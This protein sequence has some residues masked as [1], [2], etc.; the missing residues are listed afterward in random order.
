MQGCVKSEYN[1]YFVHV[2]DGIIFHKN[3]SIYIF[4]HLK[5]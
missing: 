1:L 2:D 3:F 4:L 5:Y